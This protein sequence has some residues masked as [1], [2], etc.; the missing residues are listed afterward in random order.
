MSIFNA[1]KANHRD[2]FSVAASPP[3]QSCACWRRYELMEKFIL[4]LSLSVLALPGFSCP[5]EPAYRLVATPDKSIEEYDVVFFGKLVQFEDLRE[6][7]QIVEF[8]VEKTIKGSLPNTVTVINRIHTSCSRVFQVKGSKYYV[9]AAE[10]N[11]SRALVI[12]GY[13]SFVPESVAI[14]KEVTFDAA[15]NK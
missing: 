10:A 7:E 4:M 6:S 14:G 5:I 8:S 15:H 3:L 1:N 11:D 13:A 12:D 2:S 9:F